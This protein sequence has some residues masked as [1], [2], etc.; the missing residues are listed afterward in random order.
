M[1]PGNLRKFHAPS[2]PLAAHELLT[3]YKLIV[4]FSLLSIDIRSSATAYQ[5]RPKL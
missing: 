5:V 3:L 4:L 2:P 1:V